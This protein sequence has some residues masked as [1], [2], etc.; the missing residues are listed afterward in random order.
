MYRKPKEKLTCEAKSILKNIK[1][2]EVLYPILRFN[3]SY[4]VQDNV[5]L[6]EVEIHRSI[7]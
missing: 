5:V 6:A 2:I 1:K 7:G 4:N 3:D